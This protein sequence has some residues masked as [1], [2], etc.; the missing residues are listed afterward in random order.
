[1]HI[2]A[3]TKILLFKSIH[4]HNAIVNSLLKQRNILI[5]VVSYQIDFHIYKDAVKS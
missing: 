4:I 5:L 2:S 1:M 3:I